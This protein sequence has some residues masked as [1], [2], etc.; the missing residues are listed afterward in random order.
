M[1]ESIKSKKKK[2]NKQKKTHNGI[3]ITTEIAHELKW[4]EFSA[5]LLGKRQTCFFVILRI[6]SFR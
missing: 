4:H 3:Q 6:S 2:K 1:V 5:Q